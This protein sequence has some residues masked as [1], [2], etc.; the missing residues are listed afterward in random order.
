MRRRL[1][2]S[3]PALAFALLAAAGTSCARKEPPAPAPA[4]AVPTAA[5]IPPTAPPSA[6]VTDVQIGRELGPDKR[7]KLPMEVFRARDTIFVSVAT[8]GGVP[9][10]TL[11]VK[12]TYQ[13]GQTVKEDSRTIDSTAPAATEFSIQK[14]GGWPKGEYKVE[15]SIAGQPPSTKTFRV[16]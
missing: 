11:H 13:D 7:V 6:H 1:L 3:I 10:T 16:S 5:P 8:D 9:S 4:A 15:V 12:W 2:R 14:P